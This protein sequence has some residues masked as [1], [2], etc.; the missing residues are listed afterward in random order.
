M[1][2][3]L[4]HGSE[5][6]INKP[7][8]GIGNIHNDY[9]LGFYCCSNIGLA[10]EWASRKNGFGYVNKYSIRDDRLN[11]LD[12]TKEPYGDVLI[13]TALLMNNRTID[14]SLTDAYPRELDYLKQHY[15]VDVNKYDVIVGYRADDSY[16]KFPESFVKS[17]ITIE[18]LRKIYKAGNLGK[19]YV[20]ISKHA[21]DLLHFEESLETNKESKTSYYD[22]KSKADKAYN[23]LINEDRYKKGTR[24]RDLVMDND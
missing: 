10:K 17:D 23:D 2:R 6:I 24:L 14:K 9:G 11:I 1:K 13:W 16:F 3:T 8:F 20:L 4:Y 12:L 22:R 19:Q 18:S 5:S 21:F 7:I 15:L